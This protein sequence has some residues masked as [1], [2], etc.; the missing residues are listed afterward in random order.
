MSNLTTEKIIGLIN[1]F[2]EHFDKLEQKSKQTINAP[3]GG[4]AQEAMQ[5]E[6]LIGRKTL[7][8]LLKLIESEASHDMPDL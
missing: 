2:I 4:L 6:A 1:D 7:R 5:I 3:F 8:R